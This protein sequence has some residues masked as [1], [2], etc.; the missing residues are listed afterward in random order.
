MHR[1]SFLALTTLLAAGCSSVQ[2]I[3]DAQ[4]PASAGAACNVTVYA[5]Q[6]QAR[7]GGEIEEL[8]IIEGTSSGSFSHTT[9]T[10]I[11]KH[12]GKACECGAQHV[13]VESRQPGGL[14]VASVSMVAFRYK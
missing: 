3:T 11:D 4:G 2:P 14:G 6:A 10:A 9:Q 7:K 12:K 5:T 13:Y 8:C 1:C